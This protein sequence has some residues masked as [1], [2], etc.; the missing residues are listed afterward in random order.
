MLVAEC[1]VVIYTNKM[2]TKT[3]MKIKVD[4]KIKIKFTINKKKISHLGGK[5]NWFK[6]IL[7]K[8]TIIFCNVSSM[9]SIK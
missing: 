2:E 3:N 5:Y 8:N 1:Y 7:V 4:N 6:L 9:E